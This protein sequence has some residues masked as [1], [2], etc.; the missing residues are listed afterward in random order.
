VWLDTYATTNK[1]LI[2]YQPAAASEVETANIL[3]LIKVLTTGR[4]N[5]LWEHGAGVNDDVAQSGGST[6]PLNQWVHLAVAKRLNGS[7][8]DLEFYHN[9]V[10]QHTATGIA[11]ATGGTTGQW[12]LGVNAGSAELWPG[13]IAEIRISSVARSSAEILANATAAAA[14]TI[15]LG[16]PASDGGTIATEDTPVSFTVADDRHLAR[17]L[18]FA[19][20][21]DLYQPEV[22]FDGSVFTANYAPHS[23]STP[24]VVGSDTR[25]IAFSVRHTDG[26]FKDPTFT[27]IGFDA[28]GHETALEPS[29]IFDGPL[30]GEPEDT[31]APTLTVSSPG[32]GTTILPATPL[33][34]DVQDDSGS[35]AFATVAVSYSDG[36]PSEVVWNGAGFGP[37]FE[38]SGRTVITNGHR[39]ALTREEGWRSNPTLT[40]T[41]LDATGNV[42]LN[43]TVAWV[44]SNPP[45]ATPPVVAVV[46][47]TLG[48]AIAKTTPIVIDVTDAVGLARAMLFARY[49]GRDGTEVVHDG[50][51]FLNPYVN[52]TSDREAISG[53]YRFTVLRTGGWPAA[54]TFLALAMDAAGQVTY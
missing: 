16:S 38:D 37:G 53:G 39:Y 43:A 45:D 24:T 47:P 27:V 12:Y 7:T 21:A 32:A 18:V 15:T 13:R 30:Y 11:N 50:Q 23:T 42:L 48:S 28:E 4:L 3:M 17:V 36:T 34:L 8:Y 40:V 52:D 14:P 25:S 20:F 31:T 10:L 2:S 22:V 35:V 26:W 9:G 33:V 1:T 49:E 46:S 19:S 41:A 54:P 5:S 44:L 29:F 6:F 51:A